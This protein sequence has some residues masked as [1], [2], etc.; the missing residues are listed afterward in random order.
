MYQ[1]KLKFWIVCNLVI[2]AASWSCRCDTDL[3]YQSCYYVT[4]A[5]HFISCKSLLLFPLVG[6]SVCPKQSN[7][8]VAF[9]ALA[10]QGCGCT[11]KILEGICCAGQ[12]TPMLPKEPLIYAHRPATETGSQRSAGRGDSDASSTVPRDV[13]SVCWFSREKTKKCKKAP[14][15]L[16]KQYSKFIYFSYLYFSIFAFYH[17]CWR[18]NYR[19]FSCACNIFVIRI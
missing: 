15:R 7:P 8:K 11:H 18:N 16:P 17:V 2:D 4:I 9:L 19:L 5:L 6:L 12:V 13:T 14:Q 10:G 3:I 1:P